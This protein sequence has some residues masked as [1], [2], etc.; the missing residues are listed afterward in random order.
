MTRERHN[1]IPD[2]VQKPTKETMPIEGCTARFDPD[3][4]IL[5]V[6]IFGKEIISEKIAGP[7]E[8][9]YWIG[10][11]D[12]DRNVDF[13]ISLN[14]QTNRYELAVYPVVDGR[15]NGRPGRA[16]RW[17]STLPARSRTCCACSGRTSSI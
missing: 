3:A 14:G 7:D 8:N 15:T 4:K 11:D 1:G 9:D 10:Y 16:F 5:S 6:S 13:N 17:P 12:G 2:T